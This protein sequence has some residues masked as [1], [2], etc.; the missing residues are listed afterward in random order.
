MTPVWR[1]IGIAV[2]ALGTCA[3]Q[4]A[5]ADALLI[6]NVTLIDG[7]GRPPVRGAHVLTDGERIARISRNSI[8]AADDI[9]RI[10]GRGKY[11]IPGLIDL[12]VHLGSPY[13][14]GDDPG[15]R[16]PPT[17]AAGIRALHSF[18]YAGVTSIYDP[19]N[20]PDFIMGLRT[21]ERTGKIVAP[22]IFASGAMIRPSG[23]GAGPTAVFVDDW[24]EAKA[25]LERYM[26]WKPDVVKI[27]HDE[28]GW[29]TRPMQSLL[30]LDVLQK[31]FEYVN[32]HGVRTTS[33]ASSEFRA[34]EA[35]FRGLDTL[36]HPIIQGP[37]S[38]EFV[39]LMAAKKIPMQSTLTIGDSYRRLVEEPE[40][41][42]Q[43]LYR[44]VLEPA[45]IDRLRNEVRP[46]YQNRAWT[47]WM[48]VMNPVAAE[49]VQHIHA[50]GG[51]IAMGSDQTDGPAAHRELELLVES[52]ISTLDVIRIATLNSAIWL[53]REHE[54]GSIEV[55]KL[56][57]LVLLTGDPVQDIDNAKQI[58]LVIR[59][60]Q[61]IDRA[62]LDLP[63]NR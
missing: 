46:Y 55:G 2:F 3:A 5:A 60:G 62:A 36:S 37:V 4:G 25:L 13:H 18:L 8:D 40:Y 48:K 9:R 39:Q 41:L 15:P 23:H 49:N 59:G 42:D 57:D 33:Q 63:V 20:F 29:G 45:E 31:V 24:P 28:F 19:G 44:A 54:L 27:L 30:P 21:R 12:H 43:P 38:D 22:R 10:D 56:A 51:I 58:E 1:L 35:I 7:T 50:A 14:A 26:A 34:R 53:G 47:W 61:L 16:V 17:E 6:E 52:G 11:L 32:E